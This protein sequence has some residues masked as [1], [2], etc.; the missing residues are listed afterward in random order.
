MQLKIEKASEKTT[1]IKPTA[2][3]LG[4]S[5]LIIAFLHL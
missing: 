1:D 4:I 3:V 5:R 2:K